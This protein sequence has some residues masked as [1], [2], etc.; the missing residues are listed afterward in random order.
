MDRREFLISQRREMGSWVLFQR[1]NSESGRLHPW[2]IWMQDGEGRFY[3]A[4]PFGTRPKE[5]VYSR[6]ESNL[7]SSY[8]YKNFLEDPLWCTE[9]NI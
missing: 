5:E 1:R 3:R 2:I 4:G 6:L 7:R 9:G 8:V